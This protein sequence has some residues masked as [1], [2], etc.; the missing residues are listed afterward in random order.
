LE[1]TEMLQR[2]RDGDVSALESLTERIYGQLRKLADNALSK[3][4]GTKSLQPTELVH[5]AYLRLMGAQHVDWKSRA[6]FMGVA[7]RQMRQILVD[8]ARRRAAEK[9]GG[10]AA[11]ISIESA[12]VDVG[13]QRGDFVDL[14]GLDLA[15][16]E[17]ARKDD[18]LG[19]LVELR[20][21]SGLTVEETAEVLGVSARTVKRDWR[22]AKA[23]LRRRLTVV[24]V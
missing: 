12:A 18:E 6:H 23:W 3:D 24:A 8:R 16:T 17:L 14:V 22:L 11:K 7:S 5:E 20:F 2:W 10:G 15:L 4:W 9:R 21:F 1:I 13:D 19:R